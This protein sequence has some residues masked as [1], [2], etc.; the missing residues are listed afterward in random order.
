MPLGLGLAVSHSPLLYRPREQWADIYEKLRGETPQPNRA[1]EE[2]PERLDEYDA[3]LRSAFDVLHNRL[4]SYKPEAILVLSSD[5]GRMFDET[6]VPQLSVFVGTDLW[7]AP[8]YGELG[9]PS[10]LREPVHVACHPGLS[11]FLADEL[12][13]E[14]FDLNVN[15]TFK[16]LGTPDEGVS[17]TL[18]DPVAR[19][20]AELETPVVPI[21]INAHRRPAVS[22][23]R[24]I[25]LGRAIAELASER[26]ERIAI[27]ASGGLS[28]DPFGYL[29]GWVDEM[30][31]GWVLNR[32]RRGRSEQLQTIW[33]LDST[34]VRGS[35][36]EIR[37]WIAVGAAMETAGARARVVDYM[38]LHHAGVGTAFA[39]WEPT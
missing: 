3:R 22:G 30:L 8:H 2:T 26:E 23:H 12:V 37:N 25:R 36:A 4:D 31:D 17:H 16:P 20:V 27:L 14:G 15:R 11:A 34:T 21:F 19:I 10:D 35:T 7:G 29:A 6:Q 38:R 33:D 24:M 1:A 18:T 9:E 5:Q 13:Y 39:V 32:L 28:G